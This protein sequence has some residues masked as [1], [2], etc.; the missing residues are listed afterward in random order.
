MGFRHERASA[1]RAEEVE[2][3]GG[4]HTIEGSISRGQ[5]LRAIAQDELGPIVPRAQTLARDLE[6]ARADVD[7]VVTRILPKVSLQ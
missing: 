6:H 2:D 4:D 5:L 1:L 3:V 7:P